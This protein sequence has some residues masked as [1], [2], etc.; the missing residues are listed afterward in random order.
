M[1]LRFAPHSRLVPL[2]VVLASAWLTAA[3]AVALP[4]DSPSAAPDP[5]T[6]AGPDSP[7]DTSGA[8][9]LLLDEPNH[10]LLL[11]VGLGGLGLFGRRTGRRASS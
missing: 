4:L 11:L 7:G 10:A 5:I 9:T 6:L 2:L 8:A 3:A 1:L